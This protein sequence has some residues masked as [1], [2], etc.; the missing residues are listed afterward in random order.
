MAELKRDRTPPGP[1]TELFDRLDQ[2]HLAAQAFYARDR[3]QGRD[4][5]DQFLDGT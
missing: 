2:L 3:D 5:E 4:R 1:I